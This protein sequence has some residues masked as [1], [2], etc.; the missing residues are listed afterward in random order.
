MFPSCL[1]SGY[2]T[3]PFCPIDPWHDCSAHSMCLSFP[4]FIIMSWFC[5]LDIP[6]LL[7]FYLVAKLT[8]ASR[9][10][11]SPLVFSYTE[12]RLF[13]CSPDV[14]LV[15]CL[16]IP[17]LYLLSLSCGKPDLHLNSPSCSHIPWQDCSS[18]FVFPLLPF[19]ISFL[20]FLSLSFISGQD[21]LLH[22]DTPS[23]S[24]Y[25]VARLFCLL[26]PP[27]L[28]LILRFPVSPQTIRN[29]ISVIITRS[30]PGG[31]AGGEAF[32][33]FKYNEPGHS[34]VAS[35]FSVVLRDQ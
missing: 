28:P 34:C 3:S 29:R 7:S 22:P 20:I 2:S 5:I 33:T 1:S 14:P 21:R 27:L 11:L 23:C 4:A 35:F 10:S 8:S 12:A 30:D 26:F 25:A 32:I 17:S 13:F 16:L 6:L 19:F 18:G 31:G 15:P 24:L 9:L